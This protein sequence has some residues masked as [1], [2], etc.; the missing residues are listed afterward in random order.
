MLE[1]KKAA[2]SPSNKMYALNTNS[3]E[4]SNYRPLLS[5]NHYLSENDW[6]DHD[7]TKLGEHLFPHCE[8]PIH[9]V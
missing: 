5:N 7:P 4:K 1:I 8:M 2:P 6:I 9:R 3:K